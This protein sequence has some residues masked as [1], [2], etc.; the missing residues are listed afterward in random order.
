MFPAAPPE[1][2][3]L[4]GGVVLARTHPARA[5]ALAE[6]INVSLEHLQP[7]MAWASQPATQE[8]MITFLSEGVAHWDARQDFGY[9]ILDDGSDAV[10]GG[11]GLHGRIGQHGL[12]I[13]Y[14]VH[15]DRI[16]QGIATSASRALTT[17]AFGIDGIERVRIQCEDGNVRS[18]R[19]PEKLGYAFHGVQLPE[20]GPCAGRPT[21]IWEVERSAWVALA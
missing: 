5:A 3:E 2:I 20:G 21:Q 1:R 7:W 16:G 11:C 17:A 18:A 4:G 12:E 19:V 6:A 14:W 10:I 13:G 9:S 8:T 15:V